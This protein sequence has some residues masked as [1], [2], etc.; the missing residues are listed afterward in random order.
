MTVPAISF[1]SM[2]EILESTEHTDYFRSFLASRSETAA[3]APLLQ[4][5]FMVEELKRNVYNQK[6]YDSIMNR[7]KKKFLDGNPFKSRTLVR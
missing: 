7:L 3:D 6:K 2:E 1:R 5:W 4:F